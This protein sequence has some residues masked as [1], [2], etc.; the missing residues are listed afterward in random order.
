M[1]GFSRPLGLFQRSQIDLLCLRFIDK[2][3][4]ERL[5]TIVE[6]VEVALEVEVVEE[7][8]ATDVI[9]LGSSKISEFESLFERDQE[10]DADT[11]ADDDS[12]DDDDTDVEDAGES[13]IVNKHFGSFGCSALSAAPA[14]SMEALPTVTAGRSLSG[15]VDAEK[16]PTLTS[17]ATFMS[18][19]SSLAGPAYQD[20]DL[21]ATPPL[22]SGSLS[23][24]RTGGGLEIT[25]TLTAMPAVDEE[26]VVKAPS[27]SSWLVS[28]AFNAAKWLWR[29]VES[30]VDDG[31]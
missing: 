27:M 26:V 28:R 15:V 14:R 29:N 10:Y 8:V 22:V 13:I 17:C 6:D 31:M 4:T 2:L 20:D 16:T 19:S 18:V 5:A 23:M 12:D 7:V 11:E 24:R 3:S 25:T 21:G 1:S 30:L 9:S